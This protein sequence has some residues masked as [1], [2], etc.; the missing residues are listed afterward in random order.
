[1]QLQELKELELVKDYL[2]I[3]VQF[4]KQRVLEEQQERELI[5]KVLQKI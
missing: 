4:L 2:K 3:R 5:L 1:V